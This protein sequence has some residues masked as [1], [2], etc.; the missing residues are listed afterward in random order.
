MKSKIELA[1][2][3]CA[4]YNRLMQNSREQLSEPRHRYIFHLKETVTDAFHKSVIPLDVI[5][6][7]CFFGGSWL[8][9]HTLR[10]R[11]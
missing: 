3:S 7:E 5:L 8:Q 9:L 4:V 6:S 2:N 11:I 10:R 1:W